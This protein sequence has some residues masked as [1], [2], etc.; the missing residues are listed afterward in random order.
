MNSR[1]HG[2]EFKNSVRITKDFIPPWKAIL[3]PGV[4][5]TVLQEPEHERKGFQIHAWNIVCPHRWTVDIITQIPMTK[6]QAEKLWLASLNRN[7]IISPPIKSSKSQKTQKRVFPE[8]LKFFLKTR[9]APSQFKSETSHALSAILIEFFSVKTVNLTSYIF[10]FD[11]GFP[12]FVPLEKRKKRKKFSVKFPS[13][14][15]HFQKEEIPIWQ[16]ACLDKSSFHYFSGRI[17]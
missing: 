7:Y 13:F 2:Q 8:I 16:T 12:S 3:L 1:I 11:A 5:F 9:S 4:R 15:R 10:L 17:S 14:F 6:T